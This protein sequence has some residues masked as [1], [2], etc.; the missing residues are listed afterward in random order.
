MLEDQSNDIPGLCPKQKEELMI[1]LDEVTV[2]DRHCKVAETLRPPYAQLLLAM[3]VVVAVVSAWLV[4]VGACG[5]ESSL[6]SLPKTTTYPV[7]A[8]TVFVAIVE[9][10]WTVLCLRLSL[11][12]S[13]LDPW[14]AAVQKHLLIAPTLMTATLLLVL[15]IAAAWGGDVL[16]GGIRG[17]G[18]AMLCAGQAWL[19]IRHPGVRVLETSDGTY[20]VGKRD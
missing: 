8:V 16:G 4:Y 14:R 3:S 11:T 13:R 6:D 15:G 12:P 19:A 5:P 17:A 18:I 10:V 9:I 2:N 7:Y 1:H 20:L